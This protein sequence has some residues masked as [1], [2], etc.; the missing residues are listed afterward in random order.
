MI[1]DSHI[2]IFS[3]S[4]C[5]D[6]SGYLADEQFNRIYASPQA[7]LI[8]CNQ[9]MAAMNDAEIDFAVAMGFPWEREDFCDEQNESLI[10]AYELSKGRILPFGSVPLSC[11]KGI[12]SRVQEIKNQ[13]FAGI[14]EIAF[15]R[16]G[17]TPGNLEFLKQ[18]LDAAQKHSMPLCLHLNE[19]VGHHYTGKYPP[20]LHLIYGALA[21]FPDA[22]VILSHWGGGLIFYE[23]MPEVSAA[24][25]KCYYDIAASIFLY[26][27]AIYDIALKI[28]A[29]KRILFGSD[30]PLVHFSRYLES[31]ARTVADPESKAD[32]L[33]G[34]ALALL[35]IQE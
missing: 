8:D 20:A 7:K 5:A 25:K 28:A 3:P 15:Y 6:R 23:L 4:V 34:N 29:S 35:K 9:A 32:I 18:L 1:V 33:G 14:G 17:I 10:R 27:D 26:S 21:D 19:P 22:T 24:L 13:G 31:I 11:G 12:E 16:D 2:H 30:Y